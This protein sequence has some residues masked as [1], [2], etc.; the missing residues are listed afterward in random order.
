[1]TFAELN[2]K[3]GGDEKSSDWSQHP[4]GGGWIN[5]SAKVDASA[6]VG[7]SAVVWGTVSGNAKVYGNAWVFGNAL[8]YG[9]AQ[10]YDSA[11]VFGGA[12][13]FGDALVYGNARVYGDA[14]VSGNAQV[15]GDAW[16]NSPLFIIGSRHS[17]TN[18]KHGHIQIGCKCETYKWWLSEKGVKFGKAAG[19]T[20]A[21]IKEYREYVKLFA[22]VG[23][24][25]KKA[26]QG[27]AGEGANP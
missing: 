27:E 20:P 2:Q 5:K 6:Y 24:K 23:V 13:V 9:N 25:T 3:L 7:E 19:Y 16:E 15:F 14:R 12:C 22:K 1:M 4:N 10:V 26:Q 21:E 18:A 11:R 8:V 17:L